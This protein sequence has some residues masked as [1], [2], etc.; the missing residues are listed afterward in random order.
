MTDSA[1]YYV[2]LHCHSAFSLLDG[3][4]LPEALLE[5]AALMGMQALALTDHDAVYG[6]VRFAKA[7]REIGVR[8]IFGSE[9]TLHDGHHLTLLVQNAAGWQNL[10]T[11]ITLGRHN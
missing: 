5:R 1:P 2:E 4:S 6:A 3:A 10:C 7:A 11:L 9:I 8:P